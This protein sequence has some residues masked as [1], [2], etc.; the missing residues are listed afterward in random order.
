M[1][2]GGR[3][4]FTCTI[5]NPKERKVTRFSVVPALSTTEDHELRKAAGAGGGGSTSTS[6]YNNGEQYVLV[7]L[8]TYFSIYLFTYLM[9]LMIILIILIELIELIE[10]NCIN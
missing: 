6:T 3:D 7:F 4:E 5:K 9:I 2:E 10:L 8:F 1:Q